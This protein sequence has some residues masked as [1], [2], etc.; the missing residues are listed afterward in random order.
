MKNVIIAVLVCALIVAVFFLGI[1]YGEKKATQT[2]ANTT[3]TT[4][5]ESVANENTN[6][7]ANEVAKTEEKST[8]T[9]N[10]SS[11]SSSSSSKMS[12]EDY[13]KKAAEY[14]RVT[15]PKEED[16]INTKPGYHK[17]VDYEGFGVEEE[18][19]VTY[20]YMWIVDMSYYKEDGEV[21]QGSGSSMAYKVKF[22]DG[23]VVDVEN[24]TDGAGQQES[25]KKMFP[26]D[27][28]KKVMSYNYDFEKFD[29]MVEDYYK[30]N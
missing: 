17:F 5:T 13:Y 24:P 3:N 8:N 29:K 7:A 28:A 27:V 2:P 9:T 22:K 14:V 25:I 15:K 16:H 4:S 19:G 20:A 6:V 23:E 26:S 21:E 11:S 10:T 30:N 1:Y 18:D 12:D